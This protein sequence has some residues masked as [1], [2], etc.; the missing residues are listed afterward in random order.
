MNDDPTQQPKRRLLDD[1]L[2]QV[3]SSIRR[4][5]DFSAL[6]FL[7][8]DNFKPLNDRHG[9]ALG[10]ALRVDAAK[11]LKSVAARWTPWHALAV[12]ISSS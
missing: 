5:G 2:R 1:R 12:M 9:H 3:L 8:L 10:D 6:M 11:K 7:D 4:H